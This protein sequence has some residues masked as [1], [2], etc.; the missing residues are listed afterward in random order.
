MLAAAQG[1]LP[2]SSHARGQ[3][4]PTGTSWHADYCS[5]KKGLESCG[6]WKK[7]HFQR[8]TAPQSKDGAIYVTENKPGGLGKFPWG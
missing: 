2:K 8:K 1:G 5:L 3:K 6:I 4:P 7:S